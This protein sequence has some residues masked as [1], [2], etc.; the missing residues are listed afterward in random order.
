MLR[1]ALAGQLLPNGVAANVREL[2][3]AFGKSEGLQ[4]GAIQPNADARIAFLDSLE[5]RAG[6][7]GSLSYD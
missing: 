6:R 2:A 4:Y 7:K 3:Q 1:K 5:G